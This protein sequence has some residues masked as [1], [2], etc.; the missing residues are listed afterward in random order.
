MKSGFLFAVIVLGATSLAASPSIAIAAQCL[1]CASPQGAKPVPKQPLVIEVE[2]SLDFSRM[3]LGAGQA[4]GTAEIDP[5][6]GARTLAG[7]LIDM[8]GLPMQGIVTIRGEPRKRIVVSLPGTV[9][10]SGTDG[11]ALQL[12]GLTTTLNKRPRLGADGSL[13]FDFGGRLLVPP[14]SDGDFRGAVQISVDYQ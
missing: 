14:G 11:G 10:I 4:G 1:L 9:V 3:G 6:S 12:S 13:R 2:T 5:G 8:G 7:G